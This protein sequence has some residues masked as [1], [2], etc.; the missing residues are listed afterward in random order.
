MPIQIKDAGV[1]AAKFSN[2]A[3][4]AQGDYKAGVMNPRRSQVSAAI[5]AKGVWSQAIQDAIT[6]DAYAKGL[7]AAGD[8]KWQTNAANLGPGRYAQ[9]VQNAQQAWQAGVGPYFQVLSGLTLPP[10]GPKG[11]NIG[12]VEMV[13]TA[14]RKA[15]V[16][17]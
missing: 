16:G 7:N 1:L 12:R 17:A 9:G 10:R 5:A 3:A 14:L 2:R 8:A 15:K 11:Q 6:R 13:D 4:A